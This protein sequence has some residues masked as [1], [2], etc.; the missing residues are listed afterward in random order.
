MIRIALMHVKLN[1][2]LLTRAE[3]IASKNITNFTKNILAITLI[4]EKQN[5]N[6]KV[7]NLFQ[8][9]NNQVM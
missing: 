1:K 7:F 5:V 8:F 3:E 2:I 6:D 4:K 9:N